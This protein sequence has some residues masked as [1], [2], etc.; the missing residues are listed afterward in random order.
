MED[1][2]QQTFIEKSL[3]SDAIIIDVR[4]LHEWNHGIIPGAL[5]ADFMEQTNF[6]NKINQLDRSKIYLLYCRSGMRSSYACKLMDSLGFKETYNLLGGI[7]SW[8]GELVQMN[9]GAFI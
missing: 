5:M 1:I 4:T 2:L 7:I 6:A 9:E 8:K 3:A